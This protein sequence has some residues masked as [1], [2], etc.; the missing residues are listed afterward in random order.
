MK[1]SKNKL[2]QIVREELESLTVL[3]E[4]KVKGKAV[5]NFLKKGRAGRTLTMKGEKYTDLGK[6]K[7]KGP[8]NKKL[9]WIELSSMA[10]ALGDEMVTL[11]EQ[12][13][14]ENRNKFFIVDPTGMRGEPAYY[15]RKSTN[16]DSA[17][18]FSTLFGATGFDSKGSAN[19]T[20]RRI[21]NSSSKYKRA[22]LKVLRGDELH[23][24]ISEA[25]VSP[26]DKKQFQSDA[27]EIL[28][29]MEKANL[30]D[31]DTD[32]KTVNN[33]LR[34]VFAKIA[35]GKDSYNN[36]L[37]HKILPKKL[38]TDLYDNGEKNSYDSVWFS[39]N[40]AQRDTI[41]KKA[42]K[43]KLN[44]SEAD[45]DENRALDNAIAKRDANRAN[46]KGIEQ[47]QDLYFGLQKLISK[48]SKNNKVKGY[49]GELTHA[50]VDLLWAVEDDRLAVGEI[51]NALKK[52]RSK[53]SEK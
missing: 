47:Y 28:D 40:D 37:F 24:D 44:I 45:V 51:F 33:T 1:I 41:L 34:M 2:K 17:F 8:D 12:K 43:A 46:R 15:R 52:V 48:V 22:T 5:G 4:R 36:R 11:D 10:S 29:N 23:E 38:N 3:S 6:G 19:T 7:W 9:N 49:G 53:I 25:K 32:F 30:V 18:E 31:K 13:I 16:D 39:M 35:G 27:Q 50:F 21:K 42:I 20:M 26:A 14:S